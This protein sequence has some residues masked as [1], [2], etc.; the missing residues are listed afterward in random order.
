MKRSGEFVVL[1]PKLIIG[2]TLLITLIFGGAIL[3]RGVHF[4]GSPE[5]LARN[6]DAL[7]FFNEIRS[8][9]GDDRIVIVA[10]TTS[11]V[12]APHFL[13]KLARLTA[14]LTALKGVSD[15]QSLANVKTIARTG[16][17]VTIGRLVPLNLLSDRSEGAALRLRSLKESVTADPLYVKHLISPDG[18]TT[19][20]SVFIEPLAEADTQRLAKQIEAVAK[21][22]A[23]G[24]ELMLAGV[25]IMDTRAIESMVKD[26][27][28]ISPVAALLCFVVF[29]V[30]FRSLWGAVLPMI[31]LVIGVVWTIGLM[32]ILG[33]SITFA[34]LSMPSVLMAV[35]SSYLFHVVN[36]YRISISQGR[37]DAT[38]P[39]R[40]GAWIGGLRFI[41]P[42][43]LV[44]GTTTMAG[45]GSLASSSVPTVRDMGM[46]EAMGVLFMLLLSLA[47][48]PAVLS[49]MPGDSIGRDEA[50]GDYAVWLNGWL[51]GITAAV[52]FRGRAV[53][54]ASTLIVLVVGAGALWMRV[55]TDYLKIFPE[56]SE[57]VKDALKLHERLAGAATIQ[58]I[59]TGDA[60]AVTRPDFMRGVAALEKFALEQPGVDAAIS[61]ADIIKRLDKTLSGREGQ[62][63]EVPRDA[64]VLRSMFDDY[65]AED[66][67]VN[68]WVSPD[69]SRAVL[70]LRTNLFGSNELRRLAETLGAWSRENLPEGASARATGS[71]VL[72]NDASDAVATSQSSS[73]AIALASIYLMMVL[74]FKSWSTGFL[75]LLPNLLPLACYFGMLGWLGITLDITTSLVASAALGL[76]VDNAVH[77]I[78]RYRQCRAERNSGSPVDE[79][80]VMWLTMLRTGKPMILANLMLVAAFLIFMLSSFVPVRTAGLMWAV[81]ILATLL[82]DLIFLPALMKTRL[83]AHAALGGPLNKSHAP[84]EIDEQN[85]QKAS[86]I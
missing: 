19:A 64:G 80:W 62:S 2:A 84:T 14:R 75:A 71:F 73:L 67:S 57:T 17:G 65:L 4:N 47:F 45:F 51:R 72:L 15:A 37:A 23:G 20:I 58:I 81:T 29:L 59:I 24:D 68:N 21:E 56:S 39:E 41:T 36:Q 70:V 35:G 52:L 44:S 79:G 48:V 33:Y 27:L 77:M 11:D 18:R 13:E 69:R 30:A 53:L 26:M 31:A 42:A 40:R 25:P 46:F 1:H 82:A 74:L 63:E 83:F 12:F 22:E 86:N 5:T 16:D 49:L 8:T 60:G 76:A 3:R 43:V 10:L 6:D 55:N 54:L 78:R 7:R 61:I 50:K 9:F 85:V 34:T 38:A 32:T 28:V 66:P